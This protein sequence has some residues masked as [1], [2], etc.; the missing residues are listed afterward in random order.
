MARPEKEKG[1]SF[2]YSVSFRP[3]AQ[4]ALFSPAGGPSAS[5]RRVPLES[6]PGG[7]PSGVWREF[8]LRT[9]QWAV[10]SAVGGHQDA[11][12]QRN[13]AG[14]AAWLPPSWV[15]AVQPHRRSQNRVCSH[16]AEAPELSH[17]WG[18][19]PTA[20]EPSLPSW[21][22]FCRI[23]WENPHESCFLTRVPGIG[24]KALSRCNCV[25]TNL[26]SLF[27]QRCPPIYDAF[28][29]YISLEH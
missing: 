16:E 23:L 4:A 3:Q 2:S 12:G 19:S 8:W 26:S 17:S 6:W 1:F 14:P 7:R 24:A 13:P 21:Q 22:T 9:G 11:K 27:V 29:S 15:P 20:A 25:L 10:L 18:D 5:V 28:T